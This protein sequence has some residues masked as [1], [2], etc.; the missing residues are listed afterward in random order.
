M[1]NL[2][3]TSITHKG[4]VLLLRAMFS[5]LGRVGPVLSIMTLPMCG[6]FAD[7]S[8]AAQGE[9]MLSLPQ[10]SCSKSDCDIVSEETCPQ[11]SA[12]R[13]GNADCDEHQGFCGSSEIHVQPHEPVLISLPFATPYHCD[14][15][16][17]LPNVP[18]WELFRV[19]PNESYER[20]HWVRE[21]E[22]DFGHRTEIV[23][24]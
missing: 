1:G 8:K 2:H 3:G 6:L 12:F 22:G 19:K 24:Y 5:T 21:Y 18:D 9:I 14:K 20:I 7:P 4:T 13:R 23:Q 15:A 17:I 11:V 10:S 16:L